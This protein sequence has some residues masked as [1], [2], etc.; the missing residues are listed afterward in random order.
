MIYRKFGNTG[1]KISTLG[2]GG[3]RLP[4]IEKDG[5]W[6]IDEDKAFPMLMKAYEKGVNYFDSAF[7]YCHSNSEYAIGTALKSVRDQ[8]MLTTKIPLGK[9]VQSKDDYRKLLETSLKR[10]DTSYINF[11]HFWGINK[12]VFD[13]KMVGMGLIQEAVKA[14]E[15]G[16]IK[17]IS[18]SFHDKPENMK[19]IIDNAPEL[20]TVLLQYNLL[21]RSNEEMIDYAASKGLGVVAMGPVGG[22]RLAAPTEL[23]TKLTGKASIA[24]YE[25][26]LRFVLGNKNVSCALSGMQTE[27]MLEKNLKIANIEETMSE[28]EWCNIK[29][30]ME[31][32]KKF[33]ELYCTGCRYCMP[34]P[35]NI[36]IPRIFNHYTY[37]NV[38]GLSGVA[39]KEYD[40]YIKKGGITSKD[41]INCGFCESKCPQKLKI[42]KELKRVEE[43]LSGLEV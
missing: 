30:A 22:G 13:E 1:E 16:L 27:E 40:D 7:Y 14:K 25:L 35:K 3:M 8:V 38:Y 20:E 5:K 21:D 19:Y 24:T 42:R 12:D 41:C 2:F 10:M 33:S 11:Y 28:N 32:I 29:L 23:Y 34:C 9:E 15:E 18:F 39:K 43:I 4:E 17:H 31:E 37:H 6:Y 36:D 26:A